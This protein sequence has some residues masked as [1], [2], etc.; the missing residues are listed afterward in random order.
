MFIVAV[1]AEILGCRV[2]MMQTTIFCPY[3]EVSTIGAGEG[4]D[5]A[6]CQTLLMTRFILKNPERMTIMPVQAIFRTKP[7]EP[8]NCPEWQPVRNSGKDHDL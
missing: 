8:K 1:I 5:P 7:H 6:T 2:V 3:P 4:G